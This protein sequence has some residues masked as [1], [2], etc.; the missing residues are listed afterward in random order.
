ML[1]GNSRG[2]P[3]CTTFRRAISSAVHFY[4]TL[5]ST[6]C[7]FCL[8]LLLPA[9]RPQ[10]STQGSRPGSDPQPGCIRSLRD[11]NLYIL[12]Q[13]PRPR[14]SY[15]ASCIATSIVG[16]KTTTE[17]SRTVTADPVFRSRPAAARCDAGAARCWFPRAA[18]QGSQA[19]RWAATAYRW[20]CRSD[21]MPI[22][23]HLHRVAGPVACC[24]V[25]YCSQHPAP[26]RAF[27][28]TDRSSDR[29][30]AM[31]ECERALRSCL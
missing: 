13:R 11:G 1:I 15:P 14:T 26:V 27:R 8:A 5:R 10:V 9:R 19:D 21:P 25:A 31:C 29:S 6:G 2:R 7:W 3:P 23:T 24:P 22:H 4:G 12:W 30:A 18:V 17:A 28:P 16:A 20:C